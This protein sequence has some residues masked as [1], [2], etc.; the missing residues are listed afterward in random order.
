M[1]RW[2]RGVRLVSA[3]VAALVTTSSDAWALCPNCLGQAK[4]LTSKQ[5]LLGLFLLVPFSLA[6]LVAR[7]IR[8]RYL[9]DADR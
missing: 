2:L 5:E 8:R 3:A 1:K 7:L 9:P 4:T 6:F